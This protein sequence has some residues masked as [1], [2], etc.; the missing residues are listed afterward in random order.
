VKKS[1]AE[2][3]VKTSLPRIFPHNWLLASI[4]SIIHASSYVSQMAANRDS[5][6]FAI[7]DLIKT[8]I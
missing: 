6:P 1:I 2:S 3:A 4:I 8:Q 5:V 7:R